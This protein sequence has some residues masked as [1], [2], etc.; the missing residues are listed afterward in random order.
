MIQ[1][2]VYVG[3]FA[4]AGFL[5]ASRWKYLGTVWVEFMEQ[6][7]YNFHQRMEQGTNSIGVMCAMRFLNGGKR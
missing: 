3:K 2:P 1:N 6:V 4:Y 7:W 5:Q